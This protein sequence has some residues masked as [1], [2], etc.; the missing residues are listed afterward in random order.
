MEIF[1]KAKVSETDSK[2]EDEAAEF[3]SVEEN[4]ESDNPQI[5]IEID[6]P[7]ADDDVQNDE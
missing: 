6:E 2:A 4:D 3:E 1:D 5:A 7:S